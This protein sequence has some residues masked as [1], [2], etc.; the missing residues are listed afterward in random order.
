MSKAW[1]FAI[2][3]TSGFLCLHFETLETLA[4]YMQLH[5]STVALICFVC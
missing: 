5:S 3:S 2:L 4:I 1:S